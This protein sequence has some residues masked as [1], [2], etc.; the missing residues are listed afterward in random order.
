MSMSAST[1]SNMYD[2]L[3]SLDLSSNEFNHRELESLMYVFANYHR[4]RE[5]NLTDSNNSHITPAVWRILV[6]LMQS[7]TSMLESLKM[8]QTRCNDGYLDSLMNALFNNS[9]LTELDLHSLVGNVTAIGRQTCV[10]ILL[11]NPN[12]SL[13]YFNLSDNGICCCVRVLLADALANNI[14]LK[15]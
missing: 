6:Q 7:P 13:E 14:R 5:L 15:K 8:G 10:A 11:R 4:L 1:E 2:G 3:E 12:I 9:R